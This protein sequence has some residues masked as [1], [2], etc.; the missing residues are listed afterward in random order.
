MVDAVRRSA[1]RRVAS[2]LYCVDSFDSARGATTRSRSRSARAGTAPTSAGSSSASSRGSTTTAAA[3]SDDRRSPARASA[4]TTRPTSRSSAPTCSRSRSARVASTTS[5]RSAGASAATP[6]T[7][8]TRWTTS[9]NAEGDHLDWL[10]GGASR[11]VLTS[12]RASGRTRPA[13]STARTRFAGLL[14][15]E[16]HPATS[17]TLWGHDVPHDWPSWRAQLAHHLPSLLAKEDCLMARNI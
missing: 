11:I 1:R 14:G 8:T 9:R 4:R 16:G 13:R 2:K 3:R 6:S 15:R 5:R 10:R 17:S 7:S 12:G